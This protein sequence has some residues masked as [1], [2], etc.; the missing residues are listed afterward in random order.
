MSYSKLCYAGIIILLQ[1]MD[2]ITQN[3]LLSRRC[4]VYACTKLQLLYLEFDG[5]SSQQQR[6]CP[7]QLRWQ[8]S[9]LK[10]L[11]FARILTTGA[12]AQHIAQSSRLRS[13]NE[14]FK[15]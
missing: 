4:A 13:Q 9:F 10:F 7:Q 1:Y 8:L 11:F 12:I 5:S 14:N 6:Y 3:V 15:R 2:A